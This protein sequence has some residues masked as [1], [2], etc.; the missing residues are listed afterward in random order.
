MFEVYKLRGKIR[1]ENLYRKR[2]QLWDQVP[3]RGKISFEEKT[4]TTSYIKDR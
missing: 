4:R 3:I 1:S 2:I